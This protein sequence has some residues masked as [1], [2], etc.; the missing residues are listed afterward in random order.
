MYKHIELANSAGVINAPLNLII[1]EEEGGSYLNQTGTSMYKHIEL[2][3]SVDVI[4]TPLNFI[5]F[6]KT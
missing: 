5:I 6:K 4:N 1:F 3:N 2:A